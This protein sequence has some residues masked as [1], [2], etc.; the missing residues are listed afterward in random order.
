MNKAVKDIRDNVMKSFQFENEKLRSRFDESNPEDT[1]LLDRMMMSLDNVKIR[2]DAN[3]GV[4]IEG[5]ISEDGRMN[6]LGKSLIEGFAR[7]MLRGN[8]AT[9]EKSEYAIAAE[10][11]MN[12]YEDEYGEASRGEKAVSTIAD[13]NVG[14]Q[15]YSPEKKNELQSE[16]QKG[17]NEAVEKMGGVLEEELEIA[18][19]EDGKIS[20]ANLPADEK[21][22]KIVLDILKQL[23]SGM[24]GG[25]GSRKDILSEIASKMEQF[26]ALSEGGSSKTNKLYSYA[27]EAS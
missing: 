24:E 14:S 8:P 23:N 10:R 15:I 3:G 22:K 27:K 4:V 19:D 18:L 17:V 26:G 9:G 1:T 16:I 7:D 11:L 25:G 13:G 20:V 2:I 12:L 21:N 6:Q 5:N